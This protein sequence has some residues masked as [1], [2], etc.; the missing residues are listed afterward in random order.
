AADR[1]ADLDV[2]AQARAAARRAERLASLLGRGLHLV[3]Q[4]VERLLHAP[5][6][7]GVLPAA[8]DGSDTEQVLDAEELHDA[9]SFAWTERDASCVP[10]LLRNRL[11]EPITATCSPLAAECAKIGS[12]W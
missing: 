3:E 11:I 1:R 7:L 2:R 9:I 6:L 8:V 5:V 4:A 12:S 10:R